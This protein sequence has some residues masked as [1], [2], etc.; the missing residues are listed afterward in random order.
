MDTDKVERE[1]ALWAIRLFL[2]REPHDEAE[3]QFHRG[4]PHLESLRTGF[5]MTGEFQEFLGRLKGVP[6]GAYAAPLFLLEP[7]AFPGIAHLFAPPSITAPVSQLCTQAQMTDPAY[8]AW[9]DAIGLPHDP[10]RKCWE[11]IW[12]AAVLQRAG[13]LRDGARGLGF[14]CGSEPLPACFAARGVEIMATD[15]PPEIIDGQGWDTTGQH[16]AGLDPMRRPALISNEL[17]EQRVRFRPADM[18]AIPADLQGFDFCWSACAYE[19]LGSIEHGLRF[20]EES[21]RTLRP[22]GLAVHT[23]EFNLTSN[24]RTFE[25]QV[26]SIFRKRDFEELLRRL[27]A[28]GHTPWPLNLHPGTGPM[29]VHIDLP[30]YGLPHLKL[31]IMEYACTSIGLV[32]QKGG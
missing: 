23:T 3:L 5:A 10:H 16:A 14:G 30:P 7:P 12:I 18:N 26:L 13:L 8:Y 21:M 1:A 4:H 24:D 9:C 17:F 6:G 28:A 15:A 25:S 29:D 31:Q 20:F 27:I 22:G 2:G 19:H 11:F 32:V